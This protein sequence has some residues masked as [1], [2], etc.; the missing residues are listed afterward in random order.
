VT[1]GFLDAD[2]VSAVSTEQMRQIED[3]AVSI[4]ISRMLMM[5]NAGAAIAQFIR[6]NF[7]GKTR[8]V[9]VAGTG[10]NGGDAF[11]SARHLAFWGADFEVSVVLAGS[12]DEIRA[13]EAKSNYAILKKLP[14]IRVSQISSLSETDQ[15]SHVLGRTDLLVVAIFGTGFRGEPRDLQGRIIRMINE[16]DN[17]PKISVDVPSGLEADTGNFV[18]AVK[19]D[20]TITMDAPKIGMV[21][22]Q[23]A[24]DLCGRILV[25]N[26]GVPK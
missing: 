22:N 12:A 14:T 4:G 10:N 7:R 19:S 25:A 8:L 13:P 20:F 18:N 9:F 17:I 16:T 5:E 23:R 21:R 15:L 3:D 11:V 26:I 1:T 6:Q 2:Y 24:R